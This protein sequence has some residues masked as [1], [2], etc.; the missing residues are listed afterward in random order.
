MSG[1]PITLTD[2]EREKFKAGEVS[3]IISIVIILSVCY[4]HYFYANSG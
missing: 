4:T 2:H 3:T 1:D